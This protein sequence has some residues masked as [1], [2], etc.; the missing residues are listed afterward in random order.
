MMQTDIWVIQFPNYRNRDGSQNIV[1][2][3]FSHVM[4]LPAWESFIELS[5]HEI[6][7]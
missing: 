3:L 1:F 6:V 4:Q 7:R 5:H 2:S